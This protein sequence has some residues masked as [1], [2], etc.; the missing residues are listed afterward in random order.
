MSDTGQT[1]QLP[2]DKPLSPEVV[3]QQL[4]S[5]SQPS[6]PSNQGGTQTFSVNQDES[7]DLILERLNNDDIEMEFSQNKDFYSDNDFTQSINL[8]NNELKQTKRS[9]SASEVDAVGLGPT[10]RDDNGGAPAKLARTDKPNGNKVASDVFRNKG[11]S[12][13]LVI[14]SMDNLNI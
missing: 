3:V 11:K 4:G 7:G 13:I 2:P 5:L 6:P 12:R 8:E 14:K 9:I 10:G 1:S